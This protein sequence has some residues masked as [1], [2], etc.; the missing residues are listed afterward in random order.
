MKLTNEQIKAII[1]KFDSRKIDFQGKL[2]QEITVEEAL[3]IGNVVIDLVVEVRIADD[4]HPASVKDLVFNIYAYDLGEEINLEFDE[5]YLK[6]LE[7]YEEERIN[8]YI[9]ELN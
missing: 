9:S 4:E 1:D 6:T 5:K 3:K 2:N 7:N 8:D